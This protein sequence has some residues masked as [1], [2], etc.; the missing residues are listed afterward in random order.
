MKDNANAERFFQ[1]SLAVNP[2][3]QEALSGMQE[4]RDSQGKG[5]GKKP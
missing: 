3:Q 4:L 2:Q 5:A 1:G